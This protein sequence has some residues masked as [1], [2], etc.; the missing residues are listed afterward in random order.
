M[1]LGLERTLPR[2]AYVSAE[3]FDREKERIFFSEWFC[4]GRE[5]EVPNSGDYL[6]LDVAGESVLLV[7]GASGTLSA[8][9]NLCRHRGSRLVP[10]ALP[11]TESGASVG[12]TGRLG[13]SIRCPYH[14]WTYE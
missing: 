5:E 3:F 2:D 14:S 7:R 1:K 6:V 12:P 13:N 9:Y 10:D 8:Y 4:V 11:K